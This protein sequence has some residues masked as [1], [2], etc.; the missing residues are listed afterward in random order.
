MIN[1]PIKIKDPVITFLQLTRLKELL[2]F[3]KMNK[4]TIKYWYKHVILHFGGSGV[5]A[6]EIGMSF[7]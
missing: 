2:Y 1:S 3:S 5:V 4:E 6:T 7:S